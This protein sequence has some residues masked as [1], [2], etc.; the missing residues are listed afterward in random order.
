MSSCNATIQVGEQTVTCTRSDDHGPATGRKHSALPAG[1]NWIDDSPGATPHRD[2]E[3]RYRVEKSPVADF[4]HW[5]VVVDGYPGT[6]AEY[7]GEVHPDSQ[8]A[9]EAEAA[10][11][12]GKSEGRILTDLVRHTA[13]QRDAARAEFDRY[14]QALTAIAGRHDGHDTDCFR[15]VARRVLDGGTP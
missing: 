7:N 10:R 4:E 14:H 5:W 15:C 1:V 12:N 8:G 3:P 13:D 11:L 2:P 6:V 9:A